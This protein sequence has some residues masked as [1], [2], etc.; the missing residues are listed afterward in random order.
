LRK[1]GNAGT[2]GGPETAPRVKLADLKAKKR[3][4][5]VV[6]WPGTGKKVGLLYPN[7]EDQLEA[8]F[9]TRDVFAERLQKVDESA[10][11]IF[12]REHETQLL[13]RM[14]VDPKTKNP[15]HRVA[16]NAG[17][18]RA[19]LSPNEREVLLTFY[20]GIVDQELSD[21][22]IKTTPN[23]YLR[24]IAAM[25]GLDADTAGEHIVEALGAVLRS[26]H[27]KFADDMEDDPPP[28]DSN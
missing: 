21:W 28:E 19:M 27:G 24:A 10:G 23:I 9:S 8:Y 16:E 22:G 4:V 18:L 15:D 1:P 26:V 17:V 5:E 20:Q 14:L 7:C 25:L 12:E 11:P 2:E 6:R 13:A 3:R